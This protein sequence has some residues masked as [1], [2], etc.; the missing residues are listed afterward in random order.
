M[1]LAKEYPHTRVVGF[2]IEVPDIAVTCP[3]NCAFYEGDVLQRLPFP[4]DTFDYVHQRLLV[5]AIPAVKWPDVL[6]ELVR[7]TRP[8]GW[9]ELLE[10][11][12]V[13]HNVGPAQKHLQKIWDTGIIRAG[14]DLSLMP[15]LHTMLIDAGLRGVKMEK[16]H[17]PLGKWGGHAGELMGIDI[18]NVTRGFKGF[19]VSKLGMSPET[20]DEILAV[21]PEEWEKNHT[22]YE[23]DV[24][25]GQ[26]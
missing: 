6:R 19:Y 7:V 4:N 25:Y 13:Y 10:S 23:F 8:G 14:F 11:G 22:T 2:D 26:N 21:L 17:M 12:D 18:H 3:Q 5:G 9:V 16:I 1:D 15:L 24:T 20:F